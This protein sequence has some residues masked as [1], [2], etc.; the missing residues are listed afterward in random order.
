M[1][2]QLKQEYDGEWLAIAV[3]AKNIEGP[4]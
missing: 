3:T 2:E 1:I 4:T